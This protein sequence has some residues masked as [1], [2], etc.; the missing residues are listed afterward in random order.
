MTRRHAIFGCGPLTVL[1]GAVQRA[2]SGDPIDTSFSGAYRIAT[3]EPPAAF[4]DFREFV[5]EAVD[6][7][8][9]RGRVVLGDRK[10]DLSFASGSLHAGR[11]QFTTVRSP[12]GVSYSFQ[13]DL[14][15]Q[16]PHTKTDIAV[17]EG[18]LK[19]HRYGAVKAAGKFQFTFRP[20]HA[21]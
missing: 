21:N 20:A 11:L 4:P 8:H 3:A 6:R 15:T 10:G 1:A 12:Q 13:G 18:T 9:V 5:I 19:F 7:N 14:L 17:L 16:P 2:A